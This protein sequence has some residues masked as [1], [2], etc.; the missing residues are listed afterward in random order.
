MRH[1]HVLAI[2]GTIA[3]RA[4][5]PVICT[6]YAPLL[7]AADLVESL[8]PMRDTVA[9]VTSED[10]LKIDSASLTGEH[11]LAMARRINELFSG[12]VD[13]VVVTHGTDTMEE[14]AYFLNLTVKSFKPV[15]LTGAM[16]P[17]SS[18]S[19]DG[20]L[21]LYQAI[22]AAASDA[23]RGAGTMIF[24]NGTLLAAREAC[25]IQPVRPDAFTAREMGAVGCV[26]D[27]KVEMF[28][29]STKEHT[30]STP[31]EAETLTSLPKVDILYAY[32]GAEPE[33]LDDCVKRGAK[34]IAIACVGNG[35]LR[36]VWRDRIRELAREG[37]TVVRCSRANGFVN[38]NGAQDDDA[39]GTVSGGN[40]SAQK[41]RIL[42]MLALAFTSDPA[43]IQEM[44][45]RF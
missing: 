31:F 14:T 38:R 3:S 7:S 13:G 5:D 12:D 1:I 29:H 6:T 43:E 4:A 10:F 19:A 20:P 18:M 41:A 11:W 16:R 33:L 37:I 27:G 28:Y 26:A 17:A 25:K 15:I 9:H 45:D 23:V 21:N 32:A 24:M 2:G 8:P 40:L 42:L 22:Q 35:N 44:F 34:G 36:P 39:L 30:L